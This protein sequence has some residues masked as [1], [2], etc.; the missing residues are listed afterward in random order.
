MTMHQGQ[1][2][3]GAV[4]FEMESSVDRA[5]QCNCTFCIR[6]GTTIH[7]VASKKFK[8]LSGEKTLSCY[9]SRDFSDHYFCKTCGI[10]CFSRVDF[11]DSPVVMV[12]LGCFESVLLDS[13]KPT[14]FDG[15]QKL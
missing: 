2:H 5:M 11:G 3:C 8:L 4:R 9:G 14:L 6:R 10:Q 7:Q 15:A 1:C 12:N 13:V